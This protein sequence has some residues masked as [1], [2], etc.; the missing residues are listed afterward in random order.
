MKELNK[1]LL[2]FL[3]GSLV[4]FLIACCIIGIIEMVNLFIT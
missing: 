1:H 2:V 4:G 3:Q